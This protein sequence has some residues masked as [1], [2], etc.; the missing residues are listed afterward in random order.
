[1]KPNTRRVVAI[2]IA[3]LFAYGLLLT[4]VSG[5]S[6]AAG[7]ILRAV[8]ALVVIAAFGFGAWWI[9]TQPRR[10][11]AQAAANELGL[12]FSAAD[13]FGLIDLPFALF[14][15]LASARGLENVMGGTWR[16]LQVKLFDYWYARSSDPSI[17]DTERFTCLMISLGTSWPSLLIEPET[18][19]ARLVG[20]V[21]L[22][23]IEFESEAFNRAFTVRA[24][25][26]LFASAF[27]DGRMMRW[28]LEL[29]TGRWGFQI[30]GDTLLCY[31]SPAVLP[32]ELLGVLQ[33]GSAFID[34]APSVVGSLYPAPPPMPP[35][36]V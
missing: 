14:N 6:R 1:M 35:A 28:L 30:V 33:T 23:E 7:D 19:A 34:R 15:R 16:G 36:P 9:R 22:S 18:G 5:D 13:A 31:R 21:T 11:S 8:V 12:R 17:D 10:R 3:G 4:A 27:V 32:W 20:R 26:P 2:G 24:E 29:P 25:D